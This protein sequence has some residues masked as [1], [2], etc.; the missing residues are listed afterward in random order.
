M[1]P[2]FLPLY[3]EHFD[4]FASGQKRHEYRRYGARWNEQTCW[5][6][7]PVILSYGYGRQARLQAV[8]LSFERL[9]IDAVPV[10]VS[11]IY[12]N[13]R[14]IAVIELAATIKDS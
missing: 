10:T 13:A 11:R 4:A 1:K 2:L 3:R 7:C 9:A 12:P 5:I 6:G 14:K 8:I